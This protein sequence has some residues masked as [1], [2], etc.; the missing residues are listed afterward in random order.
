MN[1]KE[2]LREG[3]QSVLGI[4]ALWVGQNIIDCPE[5]TAGVEKVLEAKHLFEKALRKTVKKGR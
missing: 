5:K 4:L 1:K 3:L 2:E